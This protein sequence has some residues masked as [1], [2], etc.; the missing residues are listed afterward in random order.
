MLLIGEATEDKDSVTDCIKLD[1]RV[2]VSM[3]DRVLDPTEM[4]GV[5]M[6]A[7]GVKA[8][9]VAILPVSALYQFASGS[10]KHSPIVTPLYPFDEIRSSIYAVRFCA[11][12]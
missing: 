4:D 11:V 12:C 5:G 7:G 3:S 6:P 8:E 10:P 2:E 1:E 9:E